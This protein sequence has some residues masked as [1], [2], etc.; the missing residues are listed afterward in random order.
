MPAG[1]LGGGLMVRNGGFPDDCCA[2]GLNG[3]IPDT[4]AGGGPMTLRQDQG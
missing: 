4:S 3:G 2:V 1:S